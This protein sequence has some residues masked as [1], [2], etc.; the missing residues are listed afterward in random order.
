[1]KT[2]R[3]RK[4]PQIGASAQNPDEGQGTFAVNAEDLLRRLGVHELSPRRMRRQVLYKQSHQAATDNGSQFVLDDEAPADEK[5]LNERHRRFVE[6]YMGACA[7]NV[8]KAYRG[9]FPRCTS[10]NAAAVHGRRLLRNAGSESGFP[11]GG[12]SRSSSSPSLPDVDTSQAGQ[13]SHIWCIYDT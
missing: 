4:A 7:G 1:M 11:A 8:T 13:T 6:L 2:K 5:P 10:D 12:V 3:L 9:A